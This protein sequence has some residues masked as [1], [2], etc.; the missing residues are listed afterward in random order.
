MSRVISN[1]VVTLER[2]TALDIAIQ[3]YGSV[4]GVFQLWAD[5]PDK[6]TSLYEEI[7]PG[8]ILRITSQPVNKAIKEA[9]KKNGYKPVS[10][11]IGFAELDLI[12]DAA[13][14]NAG[15]PFYNAIAFNGPD[16]RRYTIRWGDGSFDTFDMDND[17]P[18]HLH[19]YTAMGDKNLKAYG[20]G[21]T[22]LAVDFSPGVVK[23]INSL[24]L[25][26][27]GFSFSGANLLTSLPDLSFYHSLLIVYV[28]G[29]S[30]PVS[31]INNMLIQLDA[32]R[33]VN[34]QLDCSG[35]TPP[36]PPSGAGITA[37]NNLIA[38]GWVIG[39]D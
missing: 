26:L 34:G 30:L 38:K 37:Y 14:F 10:S 18:M 6:I 28:G 35:Q 23:S 25:S 13:A 21:M 2:Q 4:E 27:T 19:I 20:S 15:A 1:V 17:N 22:Q 7:P 24:P 29:C 16:A 12:I 39:T 32:A 36:A 3:E 11:Y 9:Y 33:L 5:N 31:A 8:T